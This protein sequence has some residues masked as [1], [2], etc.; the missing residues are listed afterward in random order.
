[1]VVH[2]MKYTV[3]RK[4]L[5][6]LTNA[7]LQDHTLQELMNYIHMDANAPPR[8]FTGCTELLQLQA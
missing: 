2:N 1:M 3:S 5:S 7:T 6:Q 4:K 8:A